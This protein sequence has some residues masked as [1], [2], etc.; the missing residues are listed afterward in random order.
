MARRKS[1]AGAVGLLI[2]L[3]LVAMGIGQ[4]L[5]TVGLVIVLVV[6]AVAIGVFIWLKSNQ[7]KARLAYLRGKYHDEAIVEQIIQHLFWEGQTSEQLKDSLG[8]P[9]S[10]DHKMLKTRKREVWKY[11]RQGMNRYAL[12]ITLDEDTVVGWDQKSHDR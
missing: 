3:C 12:R 1:N 5:D 2:I 10:V 8:N 7:R 9:A 11:D 6:C 4:I